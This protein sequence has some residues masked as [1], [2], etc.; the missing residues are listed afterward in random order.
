MNLELKRRRQEMIL[1]DYKAN[2]P[3]KDIAEFYGI[4]QTYPAKLAQRRGI[5]RRRIH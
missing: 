2:I 3:I 5:K 1:K 4:H